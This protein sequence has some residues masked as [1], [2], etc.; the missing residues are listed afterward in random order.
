[1][2]NTI[3]LPFDEGKCS[4]CRHRFIADDEKERCHAHTRRTVLAECSAV[5]NC[6]YYLAKKVQ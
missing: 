3:K 1:M 2:S 4:T 6:N 5:K